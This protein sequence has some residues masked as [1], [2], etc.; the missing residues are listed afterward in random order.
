MMVNAMKTTT[1]NHKHNKLIGCCL[2][3]TIDHSQSTGFSPS[4][5]ALGKVMVNMMEYFHHIFCF[6]LS[7]QHSLLKKEI[8]GAVLLYYMHCPR[9]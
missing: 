6:A 2:Y 5:E 7:R 8:K 4:F 1:M 3:N 9:A